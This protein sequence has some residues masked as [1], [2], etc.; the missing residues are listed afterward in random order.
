M[1]KLV[2]KCIGRLKYA[3][4]W[5]ELNKELYIKAF[6]E[7]SYLYHTTPFKRLQRILKD[8]YL[9][10]SYSHL[11]KGMICFT[12]D[13][14]RHL[15]NF[16]GLSLVLGFVEMDTY[17]KFPYDYLKEKGAKPVF[18]EVDEYQL[19]E[20]S[21]RAPY[22]LEHLV[23]GQELREEYGELFDDYCYSTWIN[24]NEW[25]VKADRVEIPDEA[26]VYVSS[27]YQ[28][29]KARSLTKL[30]VHLWKD[31]LVIKRGIREINKRNKL[32]WK[33]ELRSEEEILKRLLEKKDKLI[34]FYTL[35]T[36]RKL[37]RNQVK[38]V[39]YY[40]RKLKLPL[41][42]LRSLKVEEHV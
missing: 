39:N 18:Y 1:L 20:L 30:P 29:R 40:R 13:P 24:E 15:S 14:L 17:I 3:E 37:I 27:Y 23:T 32:C 10:S 11:H 42:S 8:G 35:K 6:L 31:V 41:L 21:V 2:E 26:E 22:W 28:L 19:R 36:Y 12:T 38:T 34:G 5:R 4:L 7:D 25:R 16:Q 33:E 9:S